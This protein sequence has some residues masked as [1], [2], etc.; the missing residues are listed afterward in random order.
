MNSSE[1]KISSDGLWLAAV[2]AAGG[3]TVHAP[4][5][6]DAG[7]P[8]PPALAIASLVAKARSDGRGALINDLRAWDSV[9]GP[10][11]LTTRIGRAAR[12]IEHLIERKDQPATRAN[13]SSK[14]RRALIAD[15]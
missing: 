9:N 3:A 14:I 8:L 12:A 15:L 6:K 4:D 1:I 11:Q 7:Q 5:H 10:S 13:I 2:E